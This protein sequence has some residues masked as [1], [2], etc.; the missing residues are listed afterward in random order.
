MKIISPTF[1][2]CM[3][4]FTA[5]FYN[6]AAAQTDLAKLPDYKHAVIHINFLGIPSLGFE[7]GLFHGFTLRQELGSGWP[8]LTLDNADSGEETQPLVNPFFSIE[9]RN[10]YNL[11]SRFNKSKPTENFYGDYVSIYYRY[12]TFEYPLSAPWTEVN[13]LNRDIHYLTANWGMQRSIGAKQH[14]YYNYSI[15]C[16]LKTDFIKN[17]YFTVLGHVEFGVQF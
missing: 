13:E 11:K 8:F 1:K 9:L 6:T 10:Y 4:L 12:N 16:G 3:I 5:V 7:K 14:F 2:W 15:G 17:N